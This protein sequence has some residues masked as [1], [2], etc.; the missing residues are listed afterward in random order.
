MI[1]HSCKIFAFTM[2]GVTALTGCNVQ[3]NEEAVQGKS[4]ESASSPT[5]TSTSTTSESEATSPSP[6]SSTSQASKSNL[7]VASNSVESQGITKKYS[8]DGDVYDVLGDHIVG[9][10]SANSIAVASLSSGDNLVGISLEDVQQSSG[11]KHESIVGA[12]LMKKSVIVIM[13]S[14]AGEDKY[15]TGEDE[16]AFAV[17][18]TE[19]GKQIGDT[20]YSDIYSSS[21]RDALVN[22][23]SYTTWAA[24]VPGESYVLMKNQDTVISK[25]ADSGNAAIFE[26][27]KPPKTQVISDNDF[28]VSHVLQGGNLVAVPGYTHNRHTTQIGADQVIAYADAGKYS[29]ATPFVTSIEGAA[30]AATTGTEFPISNFSNRESLKNGNSIAYSQDSK[31][32]VLNIAEG[33]SVNTGDVKGD[34][35]APDGVVF[36]TKGTR[37]LAVLMKGDKVLDLPS[38]VAYSSNHVVTDE[39]VILEQYGQA[40]I[41]SYSFR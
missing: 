36:G 8:I 41:Y 32:Y 30:N 37:N 19:S 22:N 23:Q 13:S 35:V 9:T 28:K 10:T 2:I 40:S 6:T 7:L 34:G 26:N 5:P 12:V 25:G 1:R 29:T 14:L 11:H 16:S 24:G 18:D 3:T 17:F 27:Q 20:V 15:N 31:N 38:D 33:T 21:A 4:Q 39:Y